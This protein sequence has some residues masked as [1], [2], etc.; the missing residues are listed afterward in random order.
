MNNVLNPDFFCCQINLINQIS[1]AQASD[2]REITEH[3]LLYIAHF[4][5]QLVC[6]EFMTLTILLLA[7]VVVFQT[8]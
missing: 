4:T 3:S 5:S 2:V 1:S 6:S 7:E 8:L